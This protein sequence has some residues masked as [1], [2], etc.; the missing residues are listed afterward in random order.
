MPRSHSKL[1]SKVQTVFDEFI[2][3]ANK[4]SLHPLDWNRF[5]SFICASYRFRSKLPGFEIKEL[6]LK[7]G[8]PQ[9]VASD[10]SSVYDHGRAIIRKAKG[11]TLAYPG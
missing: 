6:L 11:E 4:S 1:S 10:L 9:D 5:Y 3:Q 8:F 2:S 7:E